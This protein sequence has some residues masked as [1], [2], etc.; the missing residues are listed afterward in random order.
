MKPKTSNKCFQKLCSWRAPVGLECKDTVA[1]AIHQQ[2][3]RMTECKWR[4]HDAEPTTILA[5]P[6]EWGRRGQSWSSLIKV[7]HRQSLTTHK[8]PPHWYSSC[9]LVKRGNSQKQRSRLTQLRGRL[10]GLLGVGY[11]LIGQTHWTSCIFS[12]KG[13]QLPYSNSKPAEIYPDSYGFTSMTYSMQW[14]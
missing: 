3:H 14:L 1:G 8:Y 7:D 11:K 12:S 4:S 10:H 9:I 6:K 13:A 5:E 2:Q